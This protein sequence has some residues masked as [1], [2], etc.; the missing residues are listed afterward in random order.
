M[1]TGKTITLRVV[2][3]SASAPQTVSDR[4]HTLM[5]LVPLERPSNPSTRARRLRLKD[6]LAGESASHKAGILARDTNFWDYLQ[7]ISLTA[8]DA[9]IDSRRARH[10]INRVCGVSGRHELDRLTAATERFFAL[11]EQPFLKWLL[12]Y[13]SP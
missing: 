13:D 2:T 12:A 3:E 7:Q 5:Y 8:Y 10:F 6:S 1:S 11:I 4:Q 9:E